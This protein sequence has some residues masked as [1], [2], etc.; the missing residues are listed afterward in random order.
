MSFGIAAWQP[1]M[2]RDGTSLIKAADMALF[3]A[4]RQGRNTVVVDGALAA[5]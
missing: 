1:G 4:K 3:E 2:D 5:V